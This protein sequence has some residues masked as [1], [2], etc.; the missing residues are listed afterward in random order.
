MELHLYITTPIRE[1]KRQFSK[2]FPYL[3][4]EFYSTWHKKA[5]PFDP[6]QKVPGKLYLSEVTGVLKEG[7][8]NFSITTSIEEFEHRLEK[9]H[10]LPV[11]IFRK[12]ENS[13]LPI[14]KKRHLTLEKHNAIG[15]ATMHT[16]FNIHTLFL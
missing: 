11:A 6:K 1:V 12:S 15:A 9:E 16:P 8:F 13:W 3:K 7:I 2:L 4:L 14:T 5:E 10:G